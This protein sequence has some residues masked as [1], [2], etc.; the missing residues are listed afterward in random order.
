MRL[1]HE[2]YSK[3]IIDQNL[4]QLNIF[5]KIILLFNLYLGC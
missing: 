1:I 5:Y 3:I 2:V 4:K